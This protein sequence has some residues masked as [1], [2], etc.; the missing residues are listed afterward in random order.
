MNEDFNLEKSKLLEMY[1]SVVK[2][3]NFEL[4]VYDLFGLSLIPGTLHTYIGEE[5]IATGVCANLS[6]NDYIT[7]THRGHGHCIAKG[8]SLE[9]MMAELFAKK[10]GYCKAK[11]GSMHIADFDIGILGANGIV[12]GGLTIAAG[13]GLTCK[14]KYGNQRITVCFFGDGASN[15]GTFHEAI[16]LASAWKLP[17]LF[18]C[19]NNLYAMG[20]R[21]IDISNIKDIASR[22]IGYGIPGVIADGQDVLDVYQKAKEAIER[23]KKGEGPTLLECKTYRYKGH[24]KYDPANYRDPEEV[25]KWLER[26][27]IEI[28]KKKLISEYNI[29]ESSLNKIEKLVDEQ[30]ERAID[31]AKESPEP[32]L[33][34]ALDDVYTK[35]I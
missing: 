12:G 20:T 27:C 30:I 22:A 13:A 29:K 26:D 21:Q 16:N 24:S 15:Q 11:G 23:A 6:K 1:E 5:A 17:V 3:R 25:K 28:Y 4:K 32:E 2:I 31:Y 18:V 7:S 33:V 19:E 8:A 10:T 9:L 35:E 14:L 34:E